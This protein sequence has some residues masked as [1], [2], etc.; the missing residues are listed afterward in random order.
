M[1]PVVKPELRVLTEEQVHFVHDRSKFIL[2]RVGVRVDSPRALEILLASEGVTPAEHSPDGGRRVVFDEAVVEWALGMAPDVVQVYDRIGDPAFR[3]GEDRTRFGVGTTNLFYQDPTTD[4]ISPFSRRHMAVSARLAQSLP[5]F[6]LVSTIGVVRDHPPETADLVAS[7]ELIAN[8]T[9]PLALLISSDDLFGHAL[10]LAERLRPGLAEKPFLIPYL[11]PVTPLIINEG[12]A[13]K[14]MTSVER[15]LPVIYNTYGM[16]GMSTPITGAGTLTLLNAELLA[17]LVLGQLVRPGTPMILG[18]LPAYFDMKTLQDFFDPHSWLLNLA[19]SEMMAHYRIPHSGTAGCG[20][21][22]GADLAAVGQ[23]WT[24]HILSLLGKSGLAPAVGGVLGSKAFSPALVVYSNDVI[25]RA[26]RLS[27]GFPLS[28]DEL[29]L[30][31]LADQGPGGNFLTSDLT[32]NRIQEAYFE[33]QL[34]PR[35]GL[36]EWEDRDRPRFDDLLRKQTRNLLE[37]QNPP[38]DHEELI[39]KG[40]AFIQGLA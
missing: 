33:S 8:T 4:E 32:L 5:N 22:W 39:S 11:N 35:L 28:E 34:M 19:C 36:E 30:D 29:D 23:L 9:K 10:D 6:D 17:G 16:A 37:D 38:E 25:G 13:E 26:V 3:L 21:G 1:N 18:S 24:N 12:T 31:T 20:I 27:E 40:E 14:L 15:G 2:S 7:L